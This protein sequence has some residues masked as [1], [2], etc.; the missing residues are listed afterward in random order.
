MFSFNLDYLCKKS[1]NCTVPVLVVYRTAQYLCLFCTIL[2]YTCF[3][4]VLFC[5]VPVQCAGYVLYY[6]VFVQCAGYV[7]YYTVPVQSAGYVL[8][9]TVFV[10]CAGYVLYYTV[11]VLVV[12]CIGVKWRAGLEVRSRLPLPRQWHVYCTVYMV[13]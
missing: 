4:R 12:Y 10:Q 9:Y 3:V 13:S 6:T 11:P 1:N 7:L 2:P 8:Y 5:T